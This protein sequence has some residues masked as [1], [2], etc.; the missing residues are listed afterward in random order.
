M[1]VKCTQ[2]IE[3]YKYNCNTP[4]LCLLFYFR[5][6]LN[7]SLNATCNLDG[8]LFCRMPAEVLEVEIKVKTKWGK[9]SMFQDTHTRT[10]KYHTW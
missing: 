4:Y 9:F 6:A 1:G 8:Y 10:E 5:M 3:I 7:K 2:Q